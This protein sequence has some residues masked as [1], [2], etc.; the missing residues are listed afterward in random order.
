M[1]TSTEC[2]ERVEGI[3]Q[4]INYSGN[5]PYRSIGGCGRSGSPK[6]A[7]WKGVEGPNLGTYPIK[8]R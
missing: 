1:L 5:D 4:R 6:L 8:Q 2:A 3:Y 7:G